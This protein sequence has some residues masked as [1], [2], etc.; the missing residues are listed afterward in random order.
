MEFCINNLIEDSTGNTPFELA[1]SEHIRSVVNHLDG[2]HRVE[3][4]L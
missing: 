3:V 2:S 4:A 1:Y